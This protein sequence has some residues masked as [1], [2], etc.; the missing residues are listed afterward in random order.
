MTSGPSTLLTPSEVAARLGVSPIT[1]RSWVAK[2]WL[3]AQLTAGG[4]RRFLWQDVQRLLDERG[5]RL[6]ARTPPRVLVVDDDPQFRGYVV[7]TLRLLVPDIEVREAEDGFRAGLAIAEMQPDLVLLDYLMPGMNGAD[8]CR[9]I[10]ANASYSAIRV[11]AITGLASP[12]AEQ[13]LLEA[14]ADGILFKP[15]EPRRIRRVLETL[16][17]IPAEAAVEVAPA[18]T[19]TEEPL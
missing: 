10:K 11:V 15:V 14:G 13:S 4:H 19:P 5:G 9:M 2:G 16:G 8:V 17:L 18:A 1:V 3:P 7:E 12:L 6:L